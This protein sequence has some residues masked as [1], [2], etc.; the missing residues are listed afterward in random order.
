MKRMIVTLAAILLF[1]V[2]ADVFARENATFTT[3]HTPSGDR[4]AVPKLLKNPEAT[5]TVAWQEVKVLHVASI[6][7]KDD[8]QWKINQYGQMFVDGTAEVVTKA[9]KI[10]VGDTRVYLE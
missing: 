3:V 5:I 2:S 7:F 4:V 1:A 6:T 10:L 8:A 9:G